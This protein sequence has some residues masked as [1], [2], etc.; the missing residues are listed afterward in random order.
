ME[1]HIKGETREEMEISS[2]LIESMIDEENAV[3]A[4]VECQQL[5]GQKR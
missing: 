5:I 2:V 4:I 1:R 3:R